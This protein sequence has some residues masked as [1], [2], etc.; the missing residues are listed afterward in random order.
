[1]LEI[2]RRHDRKQ[3]GLELMIHLWLPFIFGLVVGELEDT[4]N[5]EVVMLHCGDLELWVNKAQ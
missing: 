4:L 3:C 5:K 1:M 2:I